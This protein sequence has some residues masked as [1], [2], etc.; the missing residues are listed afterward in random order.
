MPAS[1]GLDSPG[2]PNF[3]APNLSQKPGASLVP[4]RVP[5]AR[6]DM[7]AF[8]L[9]G[10]PCRAQRPSLG[11]GNV[12]LPR[13]GGAGRGAGPAAGQGQPPRLAPGPAFPGSPPRPH[14]SQSLA[15]W[16]A[17]VLP[18]PQ[19]RE[20]PCN[21]CYSGALSCS[22]LQLYGSIPDPTLK[23][24]RLGFSR[25]LFLPSLGAQ[26]LAKSAGRALPEVPGQPG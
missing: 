6:A 21:G 13:G 22:Q 20:A 9:A 18:G 14:P 26:S 16:T 25:R 17:E 2:P 23:A 11:A 8:R 7:G 5:G 10:P 24:S 3:P 15:D 1:P 12:A 4:Q 19:L